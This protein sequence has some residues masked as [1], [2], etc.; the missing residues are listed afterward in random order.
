MLPIE[1]LEE[2]RMLSVQ[3]NQDDHSIH[4]RGTD[5]DDVII[6]QWNQAAPKVYVISI[7]GD[8]TRI[9]RKQVDEI[10]IEGRAG[11]DRIDFSQIAG[12]INSHLEAKGGAGNDL[13]LGSS[14]HDELAGSDGN[15]TL[16]GNGGYD[17][18]YGEGGD[19]FLRGGDGDDYLYAGEGKDT[20]FGGA[21]RD[22]LDGGKD[23]DLL[24]GGGGNDLIYGG[25]GDDVIR[26]G[27]GD[28]L[29]DAGEGDD[30]VF[31]GDGNDAL[32]G[33]EGNDVLW[34][35]AGNDFLLGDDDKM[36]E[37]W[38]PDHVPGNDKLDGGDGNDTLMGSHESDTYA[39]D[40]GKDTMTGGKGD[41]YI[42]AR[43]ND[44][45]S[46]RSTGGVM[47][48]DF[49]P[50]LDNH[51]T[52]DQWVVN[53]TATLSIFHRTGR[54]GSGEYI[55]IPTGVGQFGQF[56]RV[57]TTDDSGTIH[58]R[59]TKQREFKLDE[60]FENWGYDTAD[61]RVAGLDNFNMTVNGQDTDLGPNLIVHD[62]DDIQITYGVRRFR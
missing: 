17:N 12:L 54:S 53:Q 51:A 3:W 9:A 59:D 8:A 38:G 58:M 1:I 26:M 31:G 5:K 16:I 14:G 61:G 18:L 32:C 22:Q 21:G 39:Y 25:D 43:G 47:G 27:A 7:N 41:D 34:G 35:E 57:F 2:R 29:T 15:D 20:L 33:D 6:V 19:D 37:P 55:K 28:D 56:A 23:N 44:V 4:A 52:S 36:L 62:G 11:N 30:T 10:F 45:L 49:V 42:D 60:F 13:L 46:D 24:M 40:N 48:K 50:V